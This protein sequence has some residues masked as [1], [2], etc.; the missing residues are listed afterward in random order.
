VILTSRLDREQLPFHSITVVCVDSGSPPLNASANFL[1]EVQDENDN[2]PVFDSLFYTSDV[3][4]GPAKTGVDS[5]LLHVHATDQDTGINAVI[6]YRLADGSDTDFGISRD[7]AIFV[8]NPRGVDREDKVKGT[9]RDII[10]LAIDGG[11]TRLTGT[12]TVV[13]TVRDINDNP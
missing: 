11:S 5:P 6:T 4:E 8:A 7:G 1:V 2:P 10:V 3:T 12:A 13:I 9:R